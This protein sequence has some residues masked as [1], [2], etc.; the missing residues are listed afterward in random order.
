MVGQ[1]FRFNI[2]LAQLCSST[3]V[4]QKP[5][6]PSVITITLYIQLLT[7][8]C[9]ILNM[10]SWAPFTL[11]SYPMI[12]ISSDLG[13]SLSGSWMRTPWS[14]RILL[15][16]APLRPMM[17]G[18]CLGLT[19]RVTLKLR[20]SCKVGISMNENEEGNNSPHGMTTD[21]LLNTCT[22]HTKTFK[23]TINCTY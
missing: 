19:E 18:W 8:S 3:S 16:V 22:G 7:S 2:V 14:S 10:S 1:I 20:S 17:F 12:V 6:T 5:P 4:A 23:P 21:M 11:C 15:I 9:T 13:L